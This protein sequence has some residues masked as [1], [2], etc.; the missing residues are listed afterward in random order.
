MIDCILASMKPIQCPLCHG[1]LSVA[2][3]KSILGAYSVSKRTRVNPGHAGG[4]HKKDC[5]CDKCKVKW[6]HVDAIGIPLSSGR[7]KATV[8]DRLD[9]RG[10]SLDVRRPCDNPEHAGRGSRF[11]ADCA[12][13]KPQ[14]QIDAI[15]RHNN[16][17]YEV[18][19]IRERT[20]VPFEDL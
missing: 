2:E 18:G 3:I 11:C 17:A 9:N 10:H 16:A 8:T 4:R 12:N 5:Q 19:P 6:A 7:G 14:S 20:Q 1:P 15:R 13:G